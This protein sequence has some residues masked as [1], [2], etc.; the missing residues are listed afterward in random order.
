[1]FSVVKIFKMNI[2][3]TVIINVFNMFIIKLIYF[4]VYE[5][6]ISINIIDVFQILL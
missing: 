3:L 2:D 4:S 1:M 6:I 5:Y